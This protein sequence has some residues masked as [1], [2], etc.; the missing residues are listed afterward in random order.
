MHLPVSE[1]YKLMNILLSLK[2]GKTFQKLFTLKKILNNLSL[3]LSKV[4]TFSVNLNVLNA[5]GKIEA[6]QFLFRFGLT[7]NTKI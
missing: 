6:K 3:R 1:N 4:R 2:I 5:I 7:E